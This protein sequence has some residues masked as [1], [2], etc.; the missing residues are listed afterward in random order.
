LAVQRFRQGAVSTLAD[1]VN[2]VLILFLLGLLIAA[3]P[4]RCY[5]ISS[6]PG[7]GFAL[8]QLPFLPDL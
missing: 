4:L 7:E 5:R 3:L 8:S 2:V 6:P 1:V